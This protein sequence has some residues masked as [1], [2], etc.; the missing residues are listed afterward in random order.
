MCVSVYGTWTNQVRRLE[1]SS[2]QAEGF[3]R[4][5]TAEWEKSKPVM[6]WSTCWHDD[7]VPNITL[8]ETTHV[9]HDLVEIDVDSASL[10][11]AFCHA[12]RVG[13]LV[14]CELWS[15]M[16]SRLPL[17]TNRIN[18]RRWNDQ[19]WWPTQ[20]WNRRT[21]PKNLPTEI[22]RFKN[23]HWVCNNLSK[24]AYLCK[25]IGCA[26]E[27]NSALRGLYEPENIHRPST[28]PRLFFNRT[29]ICCGAICL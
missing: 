20:Y 8:I 4:N 22:G 19:I 23:I 25:Q 24:L 1:V 12:P 26:S 15:A 11:M 27:I 7:W 2:T 29:R 18:G 16:I 21:H 17:H 9:T 13:I 5:R 10:F 14:S 3:P 28:F 6:A